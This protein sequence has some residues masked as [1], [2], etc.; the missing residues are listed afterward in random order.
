MAAEN[1]CADVR[2]DDFTVELKPEDI[3]GASVNDKDIGKLNVNQL[4]F[5]LKCRRAKQGG[6]KKGLFGRENG[7]NCSNAEV[8]NDASASLG[9]FP[10]DDSAYNKDFSILP[11]F[12]PTDT[13]DHT[14]KCGKSTKKSVDGDAIADMSSSKVLRMVLFVHDMEVSKAA[15]IV[16]AEC[17]KICPAGRSGCCCHVMAVIWKLEKCPEIAN[18]KS[19]HRMIVHVLPNLGSGVSL[20]GEK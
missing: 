15:K 11:V 5:W 20:V 4:K 10:S 14:Q 3:P 13:L 12:V 16:A 9:K 18:C 8:E 19:L 7:I 6:N 2:L 17:D 1:I